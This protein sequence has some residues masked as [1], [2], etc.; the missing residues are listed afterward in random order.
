VYNDAAMP[1]RAVLFDLDGTL[2][3][4]E[5]EYAEAMARALDKGLGIRVSQAERD[6]IIGRSWVDIHRNEL[7]HHGDAFSWS[8]ERLI[9]ETFAERFAADTAVDVL[10]GARAVIERF[11]AYPRAIVTG[12]S[13]KEAELSIGAL[14]ME[15][16]FAAVVTSEDY[17]R[18]KPAPDGYLTGARALGVDASECLVIEDSA[19]GIAA[20]RAVGAVVIAVRAGNFVG[21]DQSAAHRVVD[22]LDEVTIELVRELVEAAR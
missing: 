5:R 15:G 7:E 20:G 22:S 19:A 11:A 2:V 9:D 17:P 10:P 8:R 4:S 14:G 12:S 6:F 18:S 21:A 3:D 13:R 16:V 1:I